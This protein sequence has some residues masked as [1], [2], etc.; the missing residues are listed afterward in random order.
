MTP[1]VRLW[2]ALAPATIAALLVAPPTA[3]VPYVPKDDATV[4]ERLPIKPG[5]PV[6]REL[7]ELRARLA[8][9]PDDLDAAVSLGHRYFRLAMAEGDP[10]FVGYAEAA[11]RPW[12]GRNPPP[13]DVLVLRAL[14]R[15]Y[16]HEF[17]GALDD[18]TA[19]AASDPGR[20]AG[21]AV[22]RRDP[23]RA[24]RL[25][26]RGERLRGVA[27]SRPDARLGRLQSLGGRRH[28]PGGT[29]LRGIERKLARSRT[30]RAGAKLWM[31]TRLAELSLVLGQPDRA[32]RHFKEALA[33]GVND[34]FLLAAY[35]DF[36]LDR[37]R[38]ADV[39]TLLGGWTRSDTLLLR[40]ALAEKAARSPALE[41]HVRTLKARFDAAAPTRREAAPAG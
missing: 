4:L 17:A 15:Q 7:R 1:I 34:Q 39:A 24:G 5:D 28:R 12:S 3:A 9:Q 30:V 16:R 29:R 38:A 35:A 33:L 20:S 23:P 27:R 37:G 22:A 32:E 31:L 21:V 14:L 10:R 13:H 19:A 41:E 2:T 6:W 40:L 11:L 8:A 36:L 25:R 26:R 18:L